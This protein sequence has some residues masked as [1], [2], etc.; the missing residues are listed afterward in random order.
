MKALFYKLR[1]IV[2]KPEWGFLSFALACFMF[3]GLSGDNLWEFLMNFEWIIDASKWSLIGGA[4][5]FGVSAHTKT[6]IGR[7]F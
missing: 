3:F 2:V 4:F 5:I 7:Y 6:T 1:K